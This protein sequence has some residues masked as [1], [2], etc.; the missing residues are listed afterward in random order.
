MFYNVSLLCGDVL[1]SSPLPQCLNQLTDFHENLQT[2]DFH[3]NLQTHSTREN[4]ETMQTLSC[5]QV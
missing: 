2:V 4:C 5:V 1:G 3:E